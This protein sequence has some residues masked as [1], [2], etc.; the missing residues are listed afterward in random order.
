MS[1]GSAA[2]RDLPACRA[3]LRPFV[4]ERY[5]FAARP[6]G[7]RRFEAAAGD[8][9][10]RPKRPSTRCG[11]PFGPSC[12]GG[13]H[14]DPARSTRETTP[15]VTAAARLCRRR[16]TSS[17]RRATAFL[18]RA[19][20][21]ASLT[22]DERREILRGMVLTRAT[23]NRLKA[24]FTSGEVRYGDARV[25]GQGLPLARPG[26]DLRRG[27]PAAARRRRIATPT[28]AGTATSSRR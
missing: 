17:S 6:V 4:A 7:A 12:G 28:D 16:S 10:M 25:P 27:D 13:S 3:R 21:R 24:F 19:A 26:G 9:P 1:S 15:G 2:P 20:H 8:P 5:P 22:A 18:R 11:A 14:G 23:D